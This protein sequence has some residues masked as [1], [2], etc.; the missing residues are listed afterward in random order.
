MAVMRLTRMGAEKKAVWKLSTG[1]KKPLIWVSARFCSLPVDKDG[2][3]DG[4]D[5]ELLKK[6]LLSPLFQ[7]SLTVA[8]EN[9]ESLKKAV[10][11]AKV[12]ALG[13]SSIFHYNEYSIKD[14]KD[15]LQKNNINVRII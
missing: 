12:D 8:P 11:E 14:S 15:Y 5:I 1:L 7:S 10:M 13:V 4:Y 2:T 6:L 3:R 9:L